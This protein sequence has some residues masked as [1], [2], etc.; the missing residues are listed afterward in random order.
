MF[1]TSP[2][3]ECPR[4]CT[5]GKVQDLISDIGG[6]RTYSKTFGQNSSPLYCDK[7]VRQL[8]ISF[9]KELAENSFDSEVGD[10]EDNFPMNLTIAL[11]FSII[12][13]N[14]WTLRV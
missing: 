13:Q 9:L 4:R 14:T 11:S 5:V 8:V 6:S 12:F 2:S 7:V 3:V 1:H 10:G